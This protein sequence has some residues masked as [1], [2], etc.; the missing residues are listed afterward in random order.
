M[1]H[2]EHRHAPALCLGAFVVVVPS[3]SFASP[4]FAPLQEAACTG[5][6]PDFLKL[7]NFSRA[8]KSA[9]FLQCTAAPVNTR[10]TLRQ[11]SQRS[12]ECAL[13]VETVASRD[14]GTKSRK[15]PNLEGSSK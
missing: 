9:T 13:Q 3:N 14:R 8:F 10:A 12:S 6:H 2:P 5:R 15:A 4:A 7:N 1:M 11:P